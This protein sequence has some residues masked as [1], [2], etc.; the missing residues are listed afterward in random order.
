MEISDENDY[1]ILDDERGW[2]VE[3]NDPID[4]IILG[5]DKDNVYNMGKNTIYINYGSFMP[6]STTD[7]YSVNIKITYADGNY[8]IDTMNWV[9]R[10]NEPE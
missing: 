4:G 10:S 2:S 8:D 9:I 6:S 5:F 7:K 3:Y 1:F